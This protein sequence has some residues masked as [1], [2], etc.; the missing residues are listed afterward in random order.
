LFTRS[1][2]TLEGRHGHL[3]VGLKRRKSQKTKKKGQKQEEKG[4]NRKEDSAETS[5]RMMGPAVSKRKGRNLGGKEIKKMVCGNGGEK[6]P[7][8]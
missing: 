8:G 2:I 1:A 7:R 6:G 4:D 5:P 3:S